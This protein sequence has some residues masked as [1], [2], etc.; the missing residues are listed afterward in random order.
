MPENDQL[1]NYDMESSQW[2]RVHV[3]NQGGGQLGSGQAPTLGHDVVPWNL[4]HHSAFKVDASTIGVIWYD[5]PK[6]GPGSSQSAQASGDAGPAVVHCPQNLMVSTFDCNKSVWRNLKIA[7]YSLSASQLNLESR[8]R[9]GAAVYPIYDWDCDR[10]NRVLILGGINLQNPI[11]YEVKA[12]DDQQAPGVI[13]K[14]SL[15]QIDLLTAGG[16]EDM[17]AMGFDFERVS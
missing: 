3:K 16:F 5:T 11:D 15:A 9:D 1:W 13:A 17:K 8:Y 12:G 2:Q 4:V 7:T 14:M 10:V 6:M